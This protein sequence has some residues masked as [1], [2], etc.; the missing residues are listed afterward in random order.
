F[1]KAYNAVN[2]LINAATRFDTAS[3]SG[4]LLQG[5]STTTGLQTA[6]RGMV[7]ALA[8]S[9]GALQ[10]LSDVGISIAKDG[11][12]DLAVEST[13]LATALKDP[14]AVQAFFV[15][16]GGAAD[17]SAGFATRLSGFL[18]TAI[19]SGGLLGSKTTSLQSQKTLNNK[20]QD[21]LGDRLTLVEERMRKQYTALDTRMASLN[22]LGAYVA[23]Q[24]ASWNKSTD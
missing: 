12:G 10:R 15:G 7:G 13:R 18:Q 9:G 19:G 21:K 23:Q 17:G 4:A 6:L 5:D 24:V 14:T 11:A 3:Q 1:V 16:T 20:S 8:G 22:A 2:Q